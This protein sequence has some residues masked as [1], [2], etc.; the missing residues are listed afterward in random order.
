MNDKQY[1]DIANSYKTT[2]HFKDR[3]RER[4]N[5]LNNQLQWAQTFFNGQ[6]RLIEENNNVQKWSNGSIVVILNIAERHYITT[7]SISN[8]VFLDDNTYEMFKQLA[9]KIIDKR[10]RSTV[11]KIKTLKGKFVTNLSDINSSVENIDIIN[12][13]ISDEMK[14]LQKF[15]TNINSYLEIVQIEENN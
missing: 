8:S 5:V 7:Y 2:E 10:K 4:F 6:P 14:S 1:K 13:Q 15:T 11:K 3:L 12:I 9:E